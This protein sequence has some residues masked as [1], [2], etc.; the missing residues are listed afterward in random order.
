MDMEDFKL[1]EEMRDLLI[2]IR[3]ML[4]KKQEEES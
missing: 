4:K 3:D 2:E 1:I